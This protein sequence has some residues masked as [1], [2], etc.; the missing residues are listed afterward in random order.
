MGSLLHH[1]G[2]SVVVHRLSIHGTWVQWL[3]CKSLV[4]LQ[5]VGSEFH[6]QGSNPHP[7]HC[8]TESHPLEYQGSPICV[9][10]ICFPEWQVIYIPICIYFG[11]YISN[12]SRH[13]EYAYKWPPFS[14]IFNLISG[15]LLSLL[16]TLH[17]QS[18]CC[19]IIFFI[20]QNWYMIF[21]CSS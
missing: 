2:S 6:H 12:I 7:L 1:T 15:C 5:H 20:V 11:E 13:V 9:L 3:W 19:L 10:I 21:T 4:V 16:E 14:H 17:F 8:K 18:H